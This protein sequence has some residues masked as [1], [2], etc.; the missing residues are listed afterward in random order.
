MFDASRDQAPYPALP[1]R[2]LAGAPSMD[3]YPSEWEAF[4]NVERLQFMASFPGLRNFPYAPPPLVNPSFRV[5]ADLYTRD[6][7]SVEVMERF[8]AVLRVGHS[9][10]AQVRPDG[11]GRVPYEYVLK[12]LEAQTRVL[13]DAIAFSNHQRRQRM[14]KHCDAPPQPAAARQAP[15][16]NMETLLADIEMQRALQSRAAA[17]VGGGNGKGRR[18]P[19]KYN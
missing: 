6:R 9:W 17:L 10:A 12:L 1:D 11:D 19:K 4:D 7:E 14:A 8:S 18:K 5:S 16:V 2:V 13:Y 3:L 15:L